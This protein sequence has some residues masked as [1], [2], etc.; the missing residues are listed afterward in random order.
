[1]KRIL[2]IF[3]AIIAV[4]A[5]FAAIKFRKTPSSDYA[6]SNEPSTNIAALV[7]DR[8]ADAPPPNVIIILADDLGWADV[9]YRG[10][11]IQTP[12]IDRLAKEG[13]RLERFYATPYCSPTR[14]A[15]M[16]ARDPIKL[17]VAYA[18]LM[19]W[20][21]GGVSP[22]ER[23]MS[24][25]FKDAGYDTAM[26]GKWHMGHTIEQHTPNAR[27]FD[28]FYGHFNTDVSYFN[29]TF[30]GG[31]D[32]QENGK[33]VDHQG[34]Y[35]TNIHGSQAVRYLTDI[36]NPDKPFFMYL[37]F[38]APHSPMQAKEEDMAKYSSRIDTPRAPMKTY[39]AMVDSMDQAIGQVLDT[40]DQQGIADNTIIL[41]FT[42]NG[43]YYN[44]GGVNKPLRGGKLETFEGGIRVNALM[45]WPDV[46]PPDTVNDAEISVLD[47]YPTLAEAAGV[48]P[49]YTKKVDG[50]NRWEAITGTGTKMRGDPLFFVSNVPEYNQFKY[51]VKDGPLKLVQIVDH[52]RRETTIETMLFDIEKDPNEANNI[53]VDYPK[54]V[55]RLEQLLDERLGEHPVGG[56]YVKIQPHPGWRAPL[57]YADVVIPASKVNEDMWSGFGPLASMVLQENY[58]DKG[59]I[60]Y[61]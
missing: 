56:V 7:K 37:P 36:R 29:H 19:A 39:A 14:A 43:G 23:F 8:P 12:N 61:D 9:G 57:D 20:D 24:E 50:L 60:V 13:M 27:G 31:H 59:K 33:P 49:G 48:T 17:G 10:S 15:L 34:D 22:E 54:E 4:L 18:V 16:T 45:R 5:V 44:F 47:I 58:G 40:L 42:D 6:F 38:L 11:D 52:E 21:N 51:A 2:V 1:M 30:A 25:D 35:A 28:H 32:F 46:I 41:F 26:I 3:V 53:A 55:K